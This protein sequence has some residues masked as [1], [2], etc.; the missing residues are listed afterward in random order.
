ML[1]NIRDKYIEIFE[2]KIKYKDYNFMDTTFVIVDASRGQDEVY[3]R[4]KE[5]V[6]AL[7]KGEYPHKSK[8]KFDIEKYTR[9]TLND[10]LTPNFY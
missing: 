9:K 3:E 10:Y 6:N 4:V 7:I 1:E 8:I 2:R 5:H